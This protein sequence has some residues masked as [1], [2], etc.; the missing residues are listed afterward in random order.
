[1]GDEPSASELERLIARNHRETS[2]DIARL[3]QSIAAQR[4]DFD[5]YVLAQVYVADQRAW[6]D[7]I[8]RLEQ[9]YTD[10]V[11]E[12]AARMRG[13]R[14]AYWAAVGAVLAAVVGAV[15]AYLLAKGGA[16]K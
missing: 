5:R 11:R 15:M 8:T 4:Q 6:G 3:E 10:M 12:N 9:A 16:A 14:A 7:R 2:A 13:N 1:M